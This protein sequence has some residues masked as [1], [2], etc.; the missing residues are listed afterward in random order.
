MWVEEKKNF[1]LKQG[2]SS[3]GYPLEGDVLKL[4]KSHGEALSNDIA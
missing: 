1:S 2:N 3:S 4:C